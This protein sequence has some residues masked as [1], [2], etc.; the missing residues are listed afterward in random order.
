MNDP[1]NVSVWTKKQYCKCFTMM[2]VKISE[3][4]WLLILIFMQFGIENMLN[5]ILIMSTVDEI[6][7]MKTKTN[8]SIKSLQENDLV[9]VDQ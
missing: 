1:N 2:P 3:S 8:L 7:Q 5:R 6:I 4:S 9:N